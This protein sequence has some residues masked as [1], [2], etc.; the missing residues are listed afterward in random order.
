[1]KTKY[2]AIA[3]ARSGGHIIPG[4][5]LAHQYCQAHPNTNIIFFS[6]HHSFD[7][8][9]ISEH[10]VPVIH[11]ALSLDNVP[12]KWY[13]YPKF[14][15]QCV[16]S[17]CKS[18]YYLIRHRP[19]KVILMGGYISIP[20]CLAAFLLRIPREVYELNAIPGS[21]TKLLAPFATTIH[22]CFKS[23]Q[24]YFNKKKTIISNYPLRFEKSILSPVNCPVQ[25]GLNNTKKT[26]LIL[27]GSQ[28]SLELNKSLATCIAENPT[29]Q[30]KINIIHQTGAQDTTDWEQVYK[31]MAIDSIVFDYKH[32]LS[33]YYKAADLIIGRA[34]AGTIFETLFFSKPCILI[35]LEIAGN[36]HQLN[37]AQAI[38]QEY[39][40]LF[41]V[42][43]KNETE[44]L[45]KVLEKLLEA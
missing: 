41:T 37:N 42:V 24:K 23:A 2:I 12:T 7:Q 28:G 20:V 13:H 31:T 19:E 39:P 38:A 1:M 36:T 29:L 40:E 27:G 5:T 34:G 30:S 8:K 22:V 21:A 16:N 45:G 35:P 14:A 43:R 17:L 26:L 6:T 9:I 33:C 11:I 32:D 44:S 25:L 18:L 4:M 10:T 3:A 15:I